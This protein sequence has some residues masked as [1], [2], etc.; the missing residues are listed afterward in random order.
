MFVDATQIATRL[1]GD[2]IFANFFL[3]GVA[4]QQ[5]LIPIAAAAIDEAIELN[6]V[7]IDKNRLAFLWGRRYEE[8]SEAVKRAAGIADVLD[9]DAQAESLDD[10][11]EFR[12]ALLV[13]YQDQ[14]LRQALPQPGRARG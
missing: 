6:G 12:S 7:A 3:L 10:L 14:C 8:D 13:D 4:Y 11:V 9:S 1:L 5:G 2:A